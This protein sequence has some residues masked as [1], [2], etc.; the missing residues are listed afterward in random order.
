MSMAD[1]AVGPVI[2]RE[3]LGEICGLKDSTPV[4]LE[5]SSIA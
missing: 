5:Y 2:Q 3:G 4:E 1:E